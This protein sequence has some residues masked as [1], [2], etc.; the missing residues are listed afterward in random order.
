MLVHEAQE[1]KCLRL[2]NREFHGELILPSL[3][4]DTDGSGIIHV[5]HSLHFE[6]EVDGCHI[7]KTISVPIVIGTEPIRES[8]LLSPSAPDALNNRFLPLAPLLQ[9]TT[10]NAD[11]PPAYA[12]L[13]PPSFEEATHYPPAFKDP[14]EIKESHEIGFRSLYPQKN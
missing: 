13:K 4:P 12:D 2:S 7:N 5:E 1:S 14:Q 6:L 8:L 11:V 10:E 9:T 3:S